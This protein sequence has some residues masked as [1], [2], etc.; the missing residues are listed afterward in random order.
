MQ[1]PELPLSPDLSLPPDLPLP[2]PSHPLEQICVPVESAS[3]L[4]MN[5]QKEV[6]RCF[7]ELGKRPTAQRPQR[8]GG[9]RPSWS[10]SAWA[11][12]WCPESQA[13]ALPSRFGGAGRGELGRSLPLVMCARPAASCSPDRLLAFLLP[14]LDSGSERTRVGTLQVL[15]HIINSAGE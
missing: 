3:P 14:K 11:C 9:D 15:R 8:V 1:A 4:V 13:S 5:N 7:T 2:R 6:L 10:S 12:L